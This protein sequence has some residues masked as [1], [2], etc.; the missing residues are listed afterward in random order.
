MGA[1]PRAHT[2]GSVG[3]RGLLHTAGT[4][5]GPSGRSR[6]ALAGCSPSGL[7]PPQLLSAACRR[8]CSPGCTGAAKGG[9]QMPEGRC[10]RTSAGARVR[11]CPGPVRAQLSASVLSLQRGPTPAACSPRDVESAAPSPVRAP[12]G[13][14][15]QRN[16]VIYIMYL[17][18]EL[19]MAGAFVLQWLPGCDGQ[20]AAVSLCS[21]ALFSNLDPS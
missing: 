3:Q 14:K 10:C 15:G 19:L 11:L 12:L 16:K 5:A 17:P 20:E 21:T 4:S 2:P 18:A 7:L 6:P 9:H 1:D 13:G 8:R